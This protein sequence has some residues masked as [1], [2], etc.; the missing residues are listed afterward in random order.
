MVEE[1]RLVPSFCQELNTVFEF[2]GDYWHCH[3]DQ[4]LDENATHPTIKDKDGNPMTVKHIR[5]RDHQRVQDL[6]DQGYNVEIIWEIVW[7][8]FLTQWPEI[9]V[10]L[11]EHCTYTHFKKYLIQDQIIQYIQDG[12]L[13]GFVECDIEIPDHLKEY[14]SEMTPIFKNVDVCLDDVGEFMQNYAKEHSIKDVTGHLLIGSY[15]RKKLGLTTPLLQWYLKHRLV[16]TRIYT[17]VE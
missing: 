13:F 12:H 8:T 6:Q 3:A 5:T 4:F 9:K 11:A 7:Q 17:T 2:Y 16:I 1:R 14:F 10:Y 15:F